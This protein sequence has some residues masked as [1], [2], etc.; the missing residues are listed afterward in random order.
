MNLDQLCAEY[1]NKFAELVYLILRNK[2]EG[3]LTKALNVLQEQGLYAFV[4]FCESRGG[5]EKPAADKIKELTKEMLKDKLGL[6]SDGDLLEEIRKDGGLSANLD[7]LLL[8]IQVLE[9]SLIYARYHAKALKE[10]QQNNQ[11]IEGE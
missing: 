8:A 1:G 2:A 3:F 6:I 4:L 10:S 11:E 5:S 7:K 9:K